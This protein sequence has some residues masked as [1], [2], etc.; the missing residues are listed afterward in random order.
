[1]RSPSSTATHPTAA[2]W[3]R[4][5]LGAAV[6]WLALAASALVAGDPAGVGRAAGALA[7]VVAAVAVAR[8]PAFRRAGAAAIALY[9]AGLVAATVIAGM[10]STTGGDAARIQLF[11]ANANV[12][13]AALVTAFAAWAAVAPG[14]RWVWW[15]WPLVG[16]AVLHTGSRTSGG[17]LLAAGAVWLV[18]SALRGRPRFLLA[19]LVLLAVVGLA[20]VAWQRGVVEVTPNL[21]AAPNDLNHRAWRHDLAESVTVENAAAPGPFAGTTAQHL[22]ARARPNG[23]HLAHQSLFR[24]EAGVPY[25]ASI[26]LRADTPQQ[27]ILTSHVASTTCEVGAVWQRCVTPVGLGDDYAQAQ[28]H[29]R[30][31]QR[32]GSVD[33]YVFGAQYERGN[34]ATPFL[35]RRPAWVPQEMVRRY[36]LRLVSLAPENRVAVWGV[37]LDV[38]RAHPW[39]GIGLPASRDALL[40]GTSAVM[41]RGVTYAHN[42]LL[43]LWVVHGAVGLV[44]AALFVVALLSGLDRTAWARVAPLFV[45][46]ALLNTWDLTLFEIPVFPAAVVA[47]AFWAARPIE[48]DAQLAATGAGPPRP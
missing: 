17:A 6:A 26:Y 28:F 36:D 27:L 13:G 7:L 24:S 25:V 2:P 10:V 12:L 15:G 21:L 43:H 22:I 1:M 30:A 48:T 37:A 11:T 47:V 18:L 16:L 8:F 4:V 44:G 14:R 5:A 23:R 38:A 39:F 31:T 33:V 3:R 9:A 34:E 32:G 29:L 35:D 42:L 40:D 19:P 46:L 45:A 20:A 41:T